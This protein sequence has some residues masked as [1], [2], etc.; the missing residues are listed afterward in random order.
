[1]NIIEKSGALTMAEMYKLTKSP[2][3][4]KLSQ[5]KGQTID[6]AKFI[7]HEDTTQ[8]GKPVTIA[9]FETEQGE[10]YATNSGTFTR[11]F[12]DIITMCKEA[13]EPMPKQIK[14]LPKVGKSGR[15]YLQCV[16]IS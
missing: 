14:V 13:G 15:E 10:A 11:D 3:I 12:L 4:A 9:A 1:M 2:D 5:I 8:D 6:I 7:V 16:Y